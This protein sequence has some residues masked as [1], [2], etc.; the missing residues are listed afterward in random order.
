MYVGPSF[1]ISAMLGISIGT[2]QI[3]V[4]YQV[5]SFPQSHIDLTDCSRKIGW[6]KFAIV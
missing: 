6:L 4:V 5:S 2:S 1:V 3:I